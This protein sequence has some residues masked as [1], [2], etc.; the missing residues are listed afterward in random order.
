MIL[1]YIHGPFNRENGGKLRPL[2]RSSII[3][4]VKAGVCECGVCGRTGK[5]APVPV[6]YCW[7]RAD[8]PEGA[9]LYLAKHIGEW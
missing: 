7:L 1:A 4:I 2:E 9:G 6:D 3:S 8:R 5:C